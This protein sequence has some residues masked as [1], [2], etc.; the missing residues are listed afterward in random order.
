MMFNIE[1][2]DF[3]ARCVQ[4]F[5]DTVILRKPK[6]AKYRSLEIIISKALV[7]LASSSHVQRMCPLS[8]NQ[9]HN[10]FSVAIMAMCRDELCFATIGGCSFHSML[11]PTLDDSLD[12]FTNMLARNPVTVDS[13]ETIKELGRWVLETLSPSVNQY[14]QHAWEVTVVAAARAGVAKSSVCT[15]SSLRDITL[16]TIVVSQC[17]GMDIQFFQDDP[18]MKTLKAHELDTSHSLLMNIL[19]SDAIES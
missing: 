1:L 2:G 5:F 3:H 11:L 12:S 18:V 4:L 13:L 6:M 8:K 15:T 7:K 17:R 10:V 16:S 19:Q 9:C 14:D